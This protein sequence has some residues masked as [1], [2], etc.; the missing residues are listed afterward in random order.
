MHECALVF[1]RAVGVWDEV[2]A[3]K[4]LCNFDLVIAVGSAGVDYPT[5]IDHWVTFHVDLFRHWCELRAKAGRSR[6]ESFWTANYRGSPL[7]PNYNWPLKRVDCNGGSSGLI[8]TMVGLKL[9]KRVVIAGIP[10]DPNRNQYDKNAPWTEA[11][12]HRKA[13]ETYLPQ[14]K[15]RVRSMSGWTQTLL[16]APPEEWFHV[17]DRQKSTIAS[18][19]EA[20]AEAS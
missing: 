3:A 4:R 2:K 16:G 7:H 11:M 12:K 15:D 17:E 18:V 5:H 19:T 20:G 6:V 8:G 10:M 13:W 1:G 9:A 14:L